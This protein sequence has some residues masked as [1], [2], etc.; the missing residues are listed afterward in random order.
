MLHELRGLARSA[1][2]V[3]RLIRATFDGVLSAID[4][5]GGAV[6]CI[7]FRI[8]LRCVSMTPLGDPVVPDVYMRTA[9]SPGLTSAT[10]NS[11]GFWDKRASKDVA[12]AMEGPFPS[13]II[14]AIV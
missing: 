11:G 13:T 1:E 14:C 3:E 9:R 2:D 7:A 5:H 10:S 6:A 8:R 12:P 4:A